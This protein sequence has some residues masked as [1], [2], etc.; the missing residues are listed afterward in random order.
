MAVSV[1]SVDASTTIWN[2][3]LVAAASAVALAGAWAAWA[4]GR[5]LGWV[6]AAAALGV[7]ISCHILASIL[8]PPLIVAWVID[9]RR[10][11]AGERRRVIIAGLAGVVVVAVAAVPLLVHELTRDFSEMRALIA[12]LMA[13]GS[14]DA[15][16][17]GLPVRAILVALRVLEWPLVGLFVDALPLAIVVAAF[18]IGTI[19]W[20]V[21]ARGRLERD[22]MAFAAGTLAWSWIRAHPPRAVA[23]DRRPRPAGRPLP[24][25]PRS[26]RRR[27]GRRRHRRSRHSGR[28][29]ARRRGRRTGDL[30]SDGTC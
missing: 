27:S 24:R 22:A 28:A 5:A 16:G 25:V 7:A 20:R 8:A 13:I 4:Q 2:P 1:A 18:V 11:D 30:P 21:R 17:P 9:I 6:V 19:V 12:F 26:D 23:R 14:G 10:R 3:N 15:S 29:R